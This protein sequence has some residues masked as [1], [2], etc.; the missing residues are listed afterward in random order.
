MLPALVSNGFGSISSTSNQDQRKEKDERT[1]YGVKREMR[2]G[3]GTMH[4]TLT[5]DS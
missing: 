1:V 4:R 3:Y 2:F 5:F